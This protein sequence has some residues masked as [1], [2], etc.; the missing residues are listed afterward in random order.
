MKCEANDISG[1]VACLRVFAQAVAEARRDVN[2][3]GSC[4]LDGDGKSTFE[5]ERD[6]RSSRRRAA[7]A[8]RRKHRRDRE[9][10]RAVKQVGLVVLVL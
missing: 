10:D 2:D 3:G 5:A 7:S 9:V 6:L 8:R 1:T 4:R